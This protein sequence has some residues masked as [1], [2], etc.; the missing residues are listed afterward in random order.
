M[1]RR[2]QNEFP[3]SL[4]GVGH[5]SSAHDTGAPGSLASGRW[6]L[7]KPSMVLRVLASDWQFYHQL[8]CFRP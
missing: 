3:L 8:L 2:M 7:C 1:K 5:P 6:D 4:L